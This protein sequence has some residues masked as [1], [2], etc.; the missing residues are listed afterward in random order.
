MFIEYMI[1][2]ERDKERAIALGSLPLFKELYE[3]E[4]LL[5]LYPYWEQFGEQSAKARPLLQVEW[6]DELVHVT[7]VA[8]Q[9]ALLGMVTPQ[10]RLDR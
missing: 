8:V 6:Y 1:S 4:E 7:I 2:P 5:A 10:E 9:K 3:D